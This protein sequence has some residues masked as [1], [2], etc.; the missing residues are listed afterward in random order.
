MRV[1]HLLYTIPLRLRSV[2]R[3]KKVEQ[4]LEE[5][6]QFHIA[7]RIE[8]EIAAGK[9]PLEARY[10]ALRSMQG[11]E[12]R[13]EEC[14]DARRVNWLEDLLQDTRYASRTLTKTPGFTAIAVLV[15]TLGI[16]ANTAVFT[17]VNSVLLQPLPY[18]QSN[19]LF[20][21]SL[22]PKNNPFIPAG[23]NMSDRDYVR[24]HEQDHTFESLATF[25]K[26][27]VT[28][29]GAGDPVVL[30]A[31][32]VTADFCKVLRVRPAIGRTFLS[33]AHAETNVV[34]LS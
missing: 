10:A 26:E 5:E 23:A 3:R 28:L 1:R 24:F 17:I 4:E 34:L 21:I 19:R 11:I 22:A 30:N 20:L 8:Q 33:G 14:R 6:L 25:S 9:S 31:L 18:N 32:A 12:Q 29:T 2:F 15:L 16:G 7:Q 27:A 13:K